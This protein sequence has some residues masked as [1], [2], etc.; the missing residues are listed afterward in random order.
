MSRFSYRFAPQAQTEFDL[1]DETAQAFLIQKI[2]ERCANPYQQPL[3]RELKHLF[4]ISCRY[5]AGFKY[6]RLIYQV[7]DQELVIE[8]IKVGTKPSVYHPQQLLKRLAE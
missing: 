6:V 7:I 4:K 3:N 1:L 8:V 5:L 2:I